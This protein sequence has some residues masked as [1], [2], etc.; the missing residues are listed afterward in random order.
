MNT[1]NRFT[2]NESYPRLDTFLV[3]QTGKSRAF[4]QEQIAAGN[5]Q[6]DGKPCTKASQKLV[7]GQKVEIRFE[8]AKPTLL[9]AVSRPLEILF[10]DEVLLALNKPQGV[11]THPAPGHRGETLVH[12]LL[13]HLSG[14]K[15]FSEMPGERPGIVHRLDKG[16]SGVILVAKNREIQEALSSQFKNRSTKKEYEAIAWGKMLLEGRFSTPIGRDKKNRQK[17]SSK[18]EKT[19][20]ALTLWKVEKLFKY[21]TH[22]SLFP[23]T[24]RTHQL[25][26][27][28]TE[29]G[30]SIVGDSMYGGPRK[31]RRFPKLNTEVSGFLDGINETFLHA[32]KLTFTHPLSN[33]TIVLQAKRPQVFENFLDLLKRTEDGDA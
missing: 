24:G 20:N 30:H 13:A 33:E 7:A 31:H 11:V 22:L 12:Y 2:V 27:H 17:M 26:V 23:H 14:S 18:S 21:F 5:I 15:T 4:I 32:K 6:I 10:E 9:E 8:T 3:S 28:L 1:E 29:G 19:R 25:R 16:T